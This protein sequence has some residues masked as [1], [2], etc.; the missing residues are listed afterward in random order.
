[1]N[2]EELEVE[3]LLR[4]QAKAIEE[5]RRRN[6]V[7][8]SNNPIGDYTEWL[9]SKKMN[10]TLV[11]NSKAGFDAISEEGVTFQIKARRVT[12]FNRSRQLS[13]IR[14][15]DAKEFDWLI[16]VIFDEDYKILNAYLVPHES[17]GKYCAHREH[18]N[19]RVVVMDG[20]IVR[21]ECVIEIADRLD[22]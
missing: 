2:L 3:D 4:L 6:I 13:V 19:G 20:H 16:A 17:I 10:L 12:R 14:N 7:R 11:A 22:N 8:T 9:V 21:D 18:V 15:Y 1:M 5:L